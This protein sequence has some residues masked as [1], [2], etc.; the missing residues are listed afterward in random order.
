MTK[1]SAVGWYTYI[2]KCADGCF[3]TGI[4]NNLCK[5]IVEHNIGVGAKYTRARRPV[6]LVYSEPQ[7]NE[8]AARKREIQIKGWSREKKMKLIEGTL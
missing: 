1:R 4:T 8:S 7:D 5:R 2:L 3:Y 6:V